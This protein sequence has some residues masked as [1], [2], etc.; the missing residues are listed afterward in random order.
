ML[1][2]RLLHRMQFIAL[3]EPFDRGDLVAFVHDGESEAGIDAPAVDQDRAG[4]ALAM[5]AAFF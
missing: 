4:A 2:K 1:E 3:R 5:I